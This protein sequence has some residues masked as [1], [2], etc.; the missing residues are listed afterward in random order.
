MSNSTS[1]AV[2][3]RIF[4]LAGVLLGGLIAAVSLYQSVYAQETIE[5]PESSEVPVAAYVA[6]DPDDGD[7]ISWT[8]SGDDADDFSIDGGVLEFMSPPDYENPTSS[9]TSVTLEAQNTYNVTVEAS[10]G[11]KGAVGTE[12]DTTEVTVKVTNEDEDGVITLSTLQPR[13]AIQLTAELTDPDNVT[14]STIEWQWSRSS[15][16]NGPW[17]DIDEATSTASTSASYTPTADDVGSYLRATA[18]YNDG[19]GEG[20]TANGVTDNDVLADTSNKAPVFPDQDPDMDEDQSE[21]ASREVAENTAAGQP[22]GVP[23]AATDANGDTLTYTLGGSDADDFTIDRMSGQIE[24]G[25]GTTLDYDQG[26]QKYNVT[27]TATD[28]SLTSDTITVTITVTDMD[29]DP[30]LDEPTPTAGHTSKDHE[31]DTPIVTPVS[32][33]EATDQEDNNAELMWSLSGADAGRFD[34]SD[35][36]GDRV[37]LTFQAAPDFEAPTDSGRNNVYNVTVVVTD[38][39]GNTDSRDVTVTVTNK[40]EPGTVTLSAL[41]PE[42]EARLEAELE[43]PD[44]NISNLSWQWA[45]SSDGSSNWTDIFDATSPTYKPAM[46]DKDHYLRATASYKDGE[47]DTIKS[48]NDVSDNDVQEETVGNTAPDFGDQDLGIDGIQNNRTTRI[49]DENTAEAVGDP[50]MAS[51][52]TNNNPDTLTYSLGGRDDGSFTIDRSTGQISVGEGTDLDFE[53]KSSYSVTVTATDPALASAT[54]TV[55]ITVNDVDEAPT[56]TE[57]ETAIDYPEKG[58]RA[59]DTYAAT[60]PE[61]DRARPRKPLK[62]T[63]SGNDDDKLTISQRGVLTFNESPDYEEAADFGGNNVY[64]VTVTATDSGSNTAEWVVTVTVT[65]MEEDGEITL[66]TL[67]PQEAIVLTAT[68]TDPDGSMDDVTWQWA[69]STNRRT[70]TD[71]EGATSSGGVTATYTPVADDVRSYLRATASYTDGHSDGESEDKTADRVSDNPVLADTTNKSPVFP[72]QDPETEGEQ[73]NQTREVAENAAAG[74][75]VGDPVT[76]EDPNGDTLTYSLDDGTDAASFTIDRRTGQITVGAGTEL[77]HETKET[78]TVMVTAADPSDSA[79]SP[80]KDTIT[81]TIEV[82][83][84][85]EDPELGTGE[86]TIDYAEKGTGEVETYS[87]TDPEGGTIEWTLAGRDADDFSISPG[88]VLTFEA[89]PDYEKPTDTGRNNVYNVTVEAGDSEGNT[90]SREVTVTVTN[91]EEPGTVTLSTRRPEVGTGLTAML[92]DPDGVI[93]GPTWQWAWASSANR[94]YTPIPGATSATYP[95]D[96]GNSDNFLQATAT[97]TDGEGNTDK[98]AVGN[99]EFRVQATN[100]SNVAPA[101]GDQ[102]PATPGIQEDETTRR[103]PENS[104]ADTEVGAPVEAADDGELTYSLNGLDAG[105]FTIDRGSGQI[106]VGPGTGLDHET[107]QEYTVTVT[108]TDPALVSAT[109]TVTITVTDVNETPAILKKALVIGGRRSIDYPERDERDVATYTAAGPESAR[110]MWRLSGDDARDFS[111]TTGGVLAFRVTPDFE[112]PVD[113]D[114]DNEYRLTVHASDGENTAERNVTVTIANVDEP[115]EVT[116]SPDRPQIGAEITATLADPDGVTEDST[117]WRW[118]RSESADG[119][120]FG[121]ANAVL[122][123]YTPVADDVDSYLRATAVYNDAEGVGKT[124]EAVTASATTPDD[125][126]VVTLTPARP[127]IGDEVTAA[128]RDPDGGVTGETWQ[129]AKSSSATGP[130]TDI[131]GETSASYTPVEADADR[132][133]QATASY[134]DAAGEGKTA[135]AVSDAP[136]DA[137]RVPEFPVTETGARSVAENTAAGEDIGAAVAATDPEDDTLTYSLGGADMASFAIDPAT[138]QLMTKAALDF[139][140][141]ASYSVEVTATD[142][143]GESDSMMVTIGVTDVNEAPE[144]PD[145]ETGARSVAENTAA[146]ED[147]GAPVAA[148]D[149]DEGDTL[150]YSLGGADMASFAID[151]ATG[152]IM[153]SAPLDHETKDSYTVMVTATDGDG[154]SDSMM[155]TI[156]V[157]DVNEAPEFPDTETGARSV[158]ENT[159]AGEDIGAP[160]AATDPDEGDTLTYTLGGADMASFAIDAATGQLMTSAAL[161]YETKDSYTVMVTATDGDGESETVTVA[162]TVTDVNEAPEFPAAET[163][164][165]SVAENTAAGEDIGAPVAATDP[166]AGDTLTYTL[167]GDD[168]GSFAIDAATGQLMTEAALDYETKASYSVEVTADDGNGESATIDVTIGVTITV[169]DVNEAPEFPAAETGARSVAENTAAG[170]DIG[171]PVAATDPDAGDTLTYTLGGDDAGSF[172]IDAATGQLM[173]EA[174]LDYETKAS[175]SVEVTADDGNGES[176]TVMVTIGVTDVN[177]APEFPDT[178]TGARSVDENTAAGEDIGAPV[179]AT[180]PDEGDTLTYTLGGADMASF[181]ID[182]ATGQLMTSAPLDHETKDSYTVMVTATDGDGESDSIDVTI[183][184]TDVNEAPEFPDTETGAR[185]VAENTAAGEDI[186]APVAATDPDEGDTLT[187][188]LGGA[189]MA[190]FAIDAA[191]GQ[192]MT[193]APLDHETKDSYTVMVTA[194]DGDGES[195]TVMVTITVT[196]EGLDNAYDADDDGAID[197]EEALDAV[198]DYFDGNL[199]LEGALDVIDLYFDS[200]A[201]S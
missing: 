71:I 50:V 48:A 115:G 14:V 57:G 67:Q 166:D 9:T 15:S 123:T 195:A 25:A 170:E 72:D 19:H 63:L 23:V 10:D 66:S 86:A 92:T 124:A 154:E 136:V 201:T 142:G 138:G 70:W 120:W 38:S 184:V 47:G 119:P 103:V 117:T 59:V 108:A 16:A 196:N 200:Q 110:A 73:K 2:I 90:A 33:Y 52:T 161:D 11:V 97:Y 190:S 147:I 165:R 98:I 168:A 53:R 111:I 68:L 22:V 157:T 128:L 146:G 134:D 180:D 160:V 35:T 3:T 82:T 26:T 80:S 150:T 182:A 65:N 189:D 188:S 172:A 81:V 29:E 40:E 183:G 114:E 34:T 41:Q 39:E 61:D 171:A 17:T 43:D 31:E 20:E 125:D 60:D 51:D 78:Y 155:V 177:E 7:E 198:D 197:V 95:P 1:T 133:L 88:G 94:D 144:F 106:K 199:D 121:I 6:V 127:Q 89:S 49:V 44:G 194:T 156:G 186:G 91:V 18:S 74:R 116:L 191:T 164:A 163:G 104:D 64:D 141:K 143:D 12:T 176:A 101:F 167:G 151:A 105:S 132:Y 84:V 28:P 76:A 102:D 187:Y 185:S 118:A 148:T 153:T 54:I 8:L 175:Y 37:A 173:T 149:P 179:A 100:L 113:E 109:I 130:W 178:E 129:W 169:T 77:D 93:S 140:T 112:A 46:G 21:E 30:E 24:V 152:Q 13:E 122:E 107:K 56:K 174:A 42:V 139:E 137:N 27:V 126:G 58:M 192:L 131:A 62:W 32:T 55:T 36:T 85:D 159:A 162:I 87:A 96:L 83:D 99:S 158:D 45:S 193:S 5:Y 181:A 75:P 69:R 79:T 145:T 135:S 4:L